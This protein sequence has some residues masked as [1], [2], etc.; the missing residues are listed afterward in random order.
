MQEDHT[1]KSIFLEPRIFPLN[2]TTRKT[3]HEP[4]IRPAAHVDS[5]SQAGLPERP[6][7]SRRSSVSYGEL[8]GRMGK[9]RK[10]I[11]ERD[12]EDVFF[13]KGL[14]VGKKSKRM[15]H[16]EIKISQTRIRKQ[17]PNNK[18]TVASGKAP[19]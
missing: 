19:T 16:E 12:G 1:L 4:S 3:H 7:V 5:P 15:E 13:T 6:S 10:K 17:A 8:R 9:K 11:F 18:N 14:C 2:R